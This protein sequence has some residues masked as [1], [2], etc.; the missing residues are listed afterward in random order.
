MNWTNR[1]NWTNLYK[2]LTILLV[3]LLVRSAVDR[4]GFIET[5]FFSWHFLLFLQLLMAGFLITVG[6]H[7]SN[8]GGHKK[9]ISACYLMVAILLLCLIYSV[10]SLIQFITYH[11]SMYS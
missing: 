6:K 4:V 11:G 5:G 7:I 2:L 1:I 8:L 3:V 9:L 10:I